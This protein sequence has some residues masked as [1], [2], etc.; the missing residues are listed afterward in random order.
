MNYQEDMR[1]GKRDERRSRG[2]EDR[3]DGPWIL[4]STLLRVHLVLEL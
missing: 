1:V 3:V 4:D 2:R